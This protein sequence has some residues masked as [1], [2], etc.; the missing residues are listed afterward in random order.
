VWSRPPKRTKSAPALKRPAAS[1]ARQKAI[2]QLEGELN[3]QLADIATRLG[4]TERP[5]RMVAAH[6]HP[7]PLLMAL[8]ASAL[9]ASRTIP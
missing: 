3:R 9:P 2:D 7:R 4:I 5:R 1:E 8:A 6:R